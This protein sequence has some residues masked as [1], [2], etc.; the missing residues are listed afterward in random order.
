MV[1][2]AESLFPSPLPPVPAVVN[3]L[4]TLR[5]KGKDHETASGLVSRNEEESL[6]LDLL[7]NSSGDGF[8]SLTIQTK[9]STDD[10]LGALRGGSDSNE[11][12]RQSC[13]P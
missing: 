5:G 4:E 11:L 8:G 10:H 9:V 13:Q 1:D 2:W 12:C 7:T 3:V 6:V